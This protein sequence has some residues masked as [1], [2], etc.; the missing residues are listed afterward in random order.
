MTSLVVTADDFGAAVEVNE[1]VELAHRRGILTAASLMVAA[2]AAAD[3]IERARRLPRLGVGL[4]LVLVDGRPLLPAG[5]VPDLVDQNGLFLTN[6]AL[7]GLRIALSAEV[8]RQVRAEVFAQFASFAATGLRFDHVNAHKHFHVHPWIA[9]MVLEAAARHGVRAVRAPVTSGRPQG[10]GWFAAPFARSLFRRARRRG[11]VTPDR[12]FGLAETGQMTAE[13]I[14][15]TVAA[16]G[17]GLNE[18]YLHPATRDDFTGHGPGYCH[19]AEL[20]GLLDPAST[21][22]LSAHNVRLGSFASF[23]GAVA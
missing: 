6:M 21:A 10:S 19:R 11:M 13:R 7:V 23:Q 22:A 17:G 5:Q 20:E 15:A 4:H 12:V 2:P 1:A 8:R 3:A 14:R 16:L 9:G 18:L